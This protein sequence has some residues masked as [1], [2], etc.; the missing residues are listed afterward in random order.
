MHKS[1]FSKRWL[2]GLSLFIF[3]LGRQEDSSAQVTTTRQAKA[4]SDIQSIM[5]Q[6]NVIGLSVA[7][8]KKGDIIYQKAFGLKNRET[9]TPL[10]TTDLFR[11]A[12]ISKSF[13]ATSIM[14]L[15]EAGK[16]SLGDDF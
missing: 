3:L 10:A 5:K 9:G 4:E 15:V 13:S 8:V 12:S 11:I 6:M 2:L 1:F 16:L 14:Q 7:V